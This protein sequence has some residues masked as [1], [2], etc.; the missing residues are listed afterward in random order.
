MAT[1]NEYENGALTMDS[2]VK[3]AKLMF[4]AYN[5]DGPNKGKTW[6]GKPV[7][8]WSECGPS[9]QHKWIAAAYAAD[10]YLVGE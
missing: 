9:V 6:D 1:D 10:R 4:E 7:P 2:A 5:N 3:C 8:P